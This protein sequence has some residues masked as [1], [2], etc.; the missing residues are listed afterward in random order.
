MKRVYITTIVTA[1]VVLAIFLATWNAWHGATGVETLKVGFVYDNDESTPYT[2]NFMLAAR[3]LQKA[4]P[5][6]VKIYSRTNVPDVNAIE[7]VQEMAD[8]GVEIIFTNNYSDEIVKAASQFPQVQFCQSSYYSGAHKGASG[9]ETDVEIPDNYHT[10]NGTIYQGR[11]VTGVAAGMKLKEM[12]DNGVIEADEALVGYVG[13][14]SSVEIISGYTAFLMGVRSVVPQATMHVRYTGSWSSYSREKATAK[15]LIEEGCVVIAQHT[16]TIGP[17]VACEEASTTRR[18][19]HV[20]YN[21]SM[22]DIAPSTSL[23]STRVNWTPYVL[24]AV[25]AMLEG[26]EIEKHVQGSVHDNDI[27]AGLDLGWVEVLELNKQIAAYGTQEKLN[28]TIE[29][30]KKG[31]IEVYKGD[32]TGVNPDDES[33]RID[34]NRAYKE[35]DGT[36]WPTFRYILAD[37]V[38][39]EN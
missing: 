32:Y 12:I 11:Y 30:L 14:F 29:A 26:K 37:I 31:S 23:I 7:P 19:I 16:D 1:L 33:D 39:V 4:Y 24:G 25:E 18:L 35:N 6:R 21:Q 28:K 22:I 20:G 10:F 27:S 15:A 3:A 34:L 9:G 2:Y 17:A 5:D 8:K 36:S 38:T 13:A